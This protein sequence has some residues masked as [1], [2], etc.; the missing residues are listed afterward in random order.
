MKTPLVLLAVLALAPNSL[1]AQGG[2]PLTPPGAPGVTMKT[3]QEIEPRTPLIPGAANTAA[4]TTNDAA[5]HFIINQPGSYYLTGNL[6]VTKPNGIDIRAKGVTLDLGGFE[7]GRTAGTGGNGVEVDYLSFRCTVKNGTVT[8][9]DYGL[10]CIF[11]TLSSYAGTAVQLSVGNNTQVGIRAGD[12]WEITGCEVHQNNGG[13]IVGGR[14][15]TIT[16][17]TAH[18]NIGGD[19]ITVGAGSTITGS[20]SYQNTGNGIVTGTGS[21]VTDCTAH[22]NTSTGIVGGDGSTVTGCTA[23]NAV[24]NVLNSLG[25]TT[26]TNSTADGISALGNVTNSNGTSAGDDGIE[27]GGN[28]SSST[29]ETIGAGAGAHGIRATGSVTN[30]KGQS[31][32]G[33]GISTPRTISHSF[34]STSGTGF[35]LQCT[36]AIGCTSS[37]GESI[38]NKYLMP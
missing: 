37:G 23:Y 7:I 30:S 13:G 4:V 20:T 1:V 15:V 38:T 2:G 36:I 6:A 16:N 19:G 3:L 17:C 10:R 27:A 26:A 8:G 34:G 33:D 25:A 28:V 12:G 9:F 21:T 29:G 5:Y 35:G 11:F 32:G 24:G 14:G 18:L 22:S 31:A